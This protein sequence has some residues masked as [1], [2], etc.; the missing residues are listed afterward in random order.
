MI[1]LIKNKS[2][3]NESEINNIITR[4]KA[5]IITSDN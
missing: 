5:L 1:E 4:V 2:N 3:I